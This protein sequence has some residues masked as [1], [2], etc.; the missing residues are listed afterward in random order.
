MFK[1][2]TAY[3]V[4]ISDWS[5]DVCSSDLGGLVEEPVHRGV[6]DVADRLEVV[7]PLPLILGGDRRVVAGRAAV[8]RALVH[9][10]ARDLGCDHGDDLHPRSEERRVGQE[11]VRTRG[12]R[13]WPCHYKKQTIK[14]KKNR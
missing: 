4:R 12:Y 11:C 14:N 6:E 7:P 8:R 5:S 2:K 13:L 1:Q 9:A 10:E 3:D